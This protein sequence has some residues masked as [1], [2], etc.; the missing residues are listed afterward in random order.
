VKSTSLLFLIINHD[1]II[2]EGTLARKD[3]NFSCKNTC[4]VL[5]DAGIFFKEE[6]MLWVAAMMPF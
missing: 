1:T 6:N 2:L 3:E 5:Y 4:F